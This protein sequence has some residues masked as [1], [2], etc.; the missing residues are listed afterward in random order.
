[1]WWLIFYDIEVFSFHFV[2]FCFSPFEGCD[3]V[4]VGGVPI[5]TVDVNLHTLSELLRLYLQDKAVGSKMD[6]VSMCT[7]V[8]GPACW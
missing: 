6:R 2:C 4:T 7:I 8:H 1:M 5:E 3:A